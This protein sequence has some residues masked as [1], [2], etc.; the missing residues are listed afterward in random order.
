MKRAYEKLL[1]NNNLRVM[2]TAPPE[3]ADA[4]R[5][6]RQTIERRTMMLVRR[7]TFK[8]GIEGLS[9]NPARVLEQQL[10]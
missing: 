4:A 1:R 8:P 10:E 5:R 3:D 9:V 6:C 7:S 2:R